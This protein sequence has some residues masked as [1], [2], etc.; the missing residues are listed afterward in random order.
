[1]KKFTLVL[2][3]SIS[4]PASI[5]AQ[6]KIAADKAFEIPDNIIITRR[7]YIGL[8]KGNKLTIEVTG[9]VGIKRIEDMDSLL[10]VFKTENLQK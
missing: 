5:C 3:L 9:F 1:M 2:M 8:D 6:K 4:V 10:R 7:F